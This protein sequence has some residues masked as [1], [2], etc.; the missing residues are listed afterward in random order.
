MQ[1][2]D[3]DEILESFENANVSRDYYTHINVKGKGKLY[4]SPLFYDTSLDALTLFK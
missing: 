3:T 4:L 2:I 1:C